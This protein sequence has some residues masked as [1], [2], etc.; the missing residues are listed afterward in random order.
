MRRLAVSSLLL[1]LVMTGAGIGLG[2]QEKT[3]KKVRAEEEEETPRAEQ[4]KQKSPPTKS[5]LEEML[6]DALKNN[7]DIR[8]AAAKLAEA[9]AELNRT[10][11]Q[12]VQKVVTLYHAIE[13]QKKAIAL[14]ERKY[15][16]IA[17]LK[18]SNAVDAERV[19]EAQQTL[20][21]AKAKLEDLEV[22]L[23]ALLGKLQKT[24]EARVGPRPGLQ[25]YLD[26]DNDGRLD[27]L[28]IDAHQAKVTISQAEKIRKAL[29]TPVKV[30][31][32]SMMP[33]P[34]IL[35]DLGKKVPGLSFHNH[36]GDAGV[37]KLRFEEALPVSAILQ[38]LAD[39][40]GCSFFV[41]DYGILA[42]MEPGPRGAMTVEQFL[43]QKPTEEL[44]PQPGAGKNP[45]P[46]NVEGLVN[47]VDSNDM[48]TLSIGSDAGL[49]K[50]HTMEL[51]RIGASPSQSKYL[52]TIRILDV[53]AKQAYAQAVGRLTDTPRVG[54]RVASRILGK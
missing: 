44:R 23:P 46:G 25:G 48:M 16:R 43:R 4:S 53:Q 34:A 29:Q 52:G 20:A 40:T 31:Y 36:L 13:T 2:Q 50:G 17:E 19:D 5:K 32:G 41:R 45:P 9:D 12:V 24:A 8:V 21:L 28:V 15:K 54:D 35:E 26:F 38:A 30:N 42:T 1:T 33:L 3:A 22:Q 39:E 11:L 10:R 49:T 51:F 37:K 18:L 14:E 27:L 6:T 7:P 47:N